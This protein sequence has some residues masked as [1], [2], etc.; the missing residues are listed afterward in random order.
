M[1]EKTKKNMLEKKGWKVGTTTEFLGLS[2]E[3]A[4]YIENRLEQAVQADAGNDC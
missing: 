1:M 3:E 4:R 2:S